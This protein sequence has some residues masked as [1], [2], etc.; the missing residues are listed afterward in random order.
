MLFNSFEYF[1]FLPAVVLIYFLLPFRWRNPFLLIAS[2]YF[3]MSLKWEFG[4][5][6]LFISLVN[7]FAGLKIEGSAS[8][9]SR[10]LWLTLSIVISLGVLGYFK[11]AG[12]FVRRDSIIP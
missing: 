4:F 12:F 2:Y 3:Y 1:L 11:Y 6:L 5:L 7:Y 9:K 8:K 10:K